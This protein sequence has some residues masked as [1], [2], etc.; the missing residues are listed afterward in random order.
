MVA[1]LKK[2]L[3]QKDLH[4]LDVQAY[5]DFIH[6]SGACVCIRE[7]VFDSLYCVMCSS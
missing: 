3:A 7:A 4:T 2:D 5:L 6:S 1:N